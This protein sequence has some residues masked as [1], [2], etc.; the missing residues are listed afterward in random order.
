[1]EKET[2]NTGKE[3]QSGTLVYSG[4]HPDYQ[5]DAKP[6]KR[7]RYVQYERDKFSPYQNFLYK[8]ALFGLTVYTDQELKTL[9][10]KERREVKKLHEKTQMTLNL[11]KQHIVNKLSNKLFRDLFPNS[12]LSIQ[13]RRKFTITD[14]KVRNT[15]SFETLRIGKEQIIEKL[16]SESILPPDFHTLTRQPKYEG[17]A[18]TV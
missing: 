14:P 11:W 5:Q 18:Q 4:R 16:I 7:K 2:T 12:E 13:F 17:K 15:I 6:P 1:M 8:R 3:L 9:N 10:Y